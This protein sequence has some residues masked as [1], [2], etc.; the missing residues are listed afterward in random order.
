MIKYIIRRAVQAIPVLF[1][2]TIVV[3]AIL[4]AAPGGWLNVFPTPLSG[5]TNGVLHGDFGFSI[6][7]G[8]LVN[9][10]ISRAALPTLILAGTALF[11]WLGGGVLLGGCAA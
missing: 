3:Y 11:V 5:A 2:I 10:S 1:G 7:T 6:S 4:L 8:E 9:K